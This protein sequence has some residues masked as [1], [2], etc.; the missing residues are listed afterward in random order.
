M[1]RREFLKSTGAAAAAATAASPALAAPAQ[2]TPAA[3][4]IVTGLRE[5]RLALPWTEGYAGPADWA[6]RLGRSITQLSGGRYR[7]VSA[8]AVADGLAAVRSGDADLYFGSPPDTL[9]GLAFFAGLPGDRGMSPE[10]LQTWI[11]VGGG[12]EL[13]DDLAGDLGVKPLLAAHTGAHSYLLA[14]ERVESV[15]ALAG[16]A[17]Q[18]HGLARDVGRGLGLEPVTLA[19]GAIAGAMERGDVLAAECGGAIASYAL[20]LPRVASHS[21]GTNINRYGSALFL[22]VRRAL[23]DTFGSAEQAMFAAAAGGEYRQSLSEEQAHR[24]ML[25]PDAPAERTWPIAAELAHAIRGVADAVVAHAAGSDAS[26]R[27]VSE[28]YTAFRHAT[29]GADLATA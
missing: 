1:D 6:H 3:P 28:S 9:R 20:G 26:T 4:S 18:L 21:A 25:L 10:H 23:W 2:P 7:V 8:F 27:R 15:A 13:W 29:N 11:S 17:M 22:G 14:T 5:L 16:R 19:P 24:H 12:Q